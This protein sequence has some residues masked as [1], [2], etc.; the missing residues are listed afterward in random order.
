MKAQRLLVSALAASISLSIAAAQDQRT[1]ES[2]PLTPVVQQPS[3][4]LSSGEV[5]VI[6]ENGQLSIKAARVPLLQVVRRVCKKLGAAIEAPSGASEPIV[7]DLGPGPVR[8]VLTSLL[9]GSP[10]NFAMQAAVDDPRLLARLLVIPLSKD[11]GVGPNHDAVVEARAEQLRITPKGVTEPEQSAEV[12]EVVDPK[13]TK[14]QMKDLIAEARQELAAAGADM[15]DSLKQGAT[16][17]LA[18]LEK[19][20]DTLVDKAAAP[21]AEPTP[22]AP[23]VDRPTGKGPFHHRHR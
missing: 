4:E 8:Q 2:T 6:Y 13:Q 18:D 5:V 1:A 10:F 16:Q 7:V 20:M 15:D 17:L 11:G 14:A 19:S 12:E 9:E 23:A 22:T 3:P 21:D